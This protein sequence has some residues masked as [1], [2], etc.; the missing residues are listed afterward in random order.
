MRHGLLLSLL[1]LAACDHPAQP[2]GT[3]SP[4]TAPP[5]GSAPAPP[6]SSG[7]GS[8]AVAAARDTFETSAGRVTVHPVFHATLWLEVGQK[9]V[10]VDP[11]SKGKLDGPNA[12]VVLVTD[13]HPDHY[14]EAG[15]AAVRKPGS[16]V[17]APKVVADKVPGAIVLANGDKKDLGFMS[18]EAVPMYNLVRGPEAGKLY[19]DKGRGNGYVIEVGG[20][21]FYLSGDTEC[22]PEMKALRHIDVAFVCMNLPYTMTPTEAGQC[23]AAFKPKVLY[24][25]HDR[26]SNLDELD[27]A[28]AGSGV[29]VRRRS[30]Y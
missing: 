4:A 21:R 13:I 2:A 9:T 15:L 1:L 5:A 10:W 26:D 30:W 16:Q 12:D 24:P 20:K 3:T 14:D 22:I 11:W 8:G 18:V 6:A 28:L 27:K 7:S 17:V 29:E 19:H 23:V 25:Y